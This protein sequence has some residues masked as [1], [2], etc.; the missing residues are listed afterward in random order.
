MSKIESLTILYKSAS[1]QF[2]PNF[3]NSWYQPSCSGYFKLDSW[4]FSCPYILHPI[5]L[6]RSIGSLFKTD[7]E[8]DHFFS[9]S[10]LK[11]NSD[12]CLSLALTIQTASLMVFLPPSWLL[13]QYIVQTATRVIFRKCNNTLS[14]LVMGMHTH[15][16]L[17]KTF[18]KLPTEPRTDFKLLMIPLSVFPA[19]LPLLILL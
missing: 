8:S 13:L 14:P 3:I 1:S 7:P 11:L 18:Q 10:L 19:S 16:L 9:V 15:I 6:V 4:F 12:S 2:S 5:H 17:I